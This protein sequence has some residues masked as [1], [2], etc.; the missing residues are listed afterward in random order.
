MKN[1]RKETLNS[2]HFVKLGENRYLIRVSEFYPDNCCDEDEAI[3]SEEHLD[4]LLSFK[5]E[6][7][8]EQD[9]DDDNRAGVFLGDEC[10]SGTIGLFQESFISDIETELWLEQVLADMGDKAIR[11]AKMVYLEGYKNRELA[12]LENVTHEAIN[13]AMR[14]INERVSKMLKTLIEE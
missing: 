10:Y 14:K 3:V 4:Q 2:V 9:R 13:K 7:V 11:R 6:E 12:R 5:D 8:R 1:H